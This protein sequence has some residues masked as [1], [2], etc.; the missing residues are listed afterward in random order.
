MRISYASTLP[1]KV[2]NLAR[3]EKKNRH[4]SNKKVLTLE[5]QGIF[6]IVFDVMLPNNDKIAGTNNFK[7]AGNLQGKHLQNSQNLMGL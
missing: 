2:F 7:C 5:P 3:I 6:F 1:K 4:N